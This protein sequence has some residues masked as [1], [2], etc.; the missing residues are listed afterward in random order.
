MFHPKLQKEGNPM[1][2]ILTDREEQVLR[3]IA[4][5]LTNREISYDLSISESTVENHIHHIYAKLGISNR[6]QAVAYAFQFRLVLLQN[7]LLENR[8]IPS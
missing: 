4:D 5:G 7:E 2:P 8:G 3:L 1:L 6:A